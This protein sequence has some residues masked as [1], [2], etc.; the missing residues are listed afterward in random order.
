MTVKEEEKE[1][2]Q[3]SRSVTMQRQRNL[4]MY[5]ALVDLEGGG[6]KL[7]TG[8]PENREEVKTKFPW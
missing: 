8:N 4:Y 1:E 7:K 6:S 2:E 3:S 5:G